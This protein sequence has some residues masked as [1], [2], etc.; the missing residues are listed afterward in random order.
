MGVL[1]FMTAHAQNHASITPSELEAEIS[2]RLSRVPEFRFIREEAAKLGVKV[3]LFGGTAAGYAHYVKWDL[4]RESGDPRYQNDRFD[5]DFTNIY[6]STQDLDIVLDGTAEQASALRE[7]L[8]ATY[9]HFQGTKEQWEVRLL[10]EKMGTKDALL[11][12]PDFLKQHTDSNS[13]GMIEVT[14]KSSE[15][16]VR[17][18]RDWN[19]KEPFFLRDVAEGKIH[20]YFSREHEKTSRY[21]EGKNPPIFSVIRYLT[22]AFQYELEMRPEEISTIRSMIA[23]T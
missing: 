11:D 17:D 22:K 4:L 13:T 3:Y 7:R 16:V 5:Y 12:N 14:A 18:L 1:S 23:A 2:K 21:G 20:F 8:K 6:R 10:R 19:S 15:H 9:P